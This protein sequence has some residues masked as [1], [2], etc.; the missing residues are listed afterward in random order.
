MFNKLMQNESVK[1]FAIGAVGI[2]T[3]IIGYAASCAGLKAAMHAG[4][5]VF[6]G[7]SDSVDKIVNDNKKLSGSAKCASIP[8]VRVIEVD[9]KPDN[10]TSDKNEEVEDGTGDGEA[11]TE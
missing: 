4:L 8:V 2:C 6:D 7:V 1:K 11:V 5:S 9:L 3:I 10:S